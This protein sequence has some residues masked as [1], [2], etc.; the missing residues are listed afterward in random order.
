VL[1]LVLFEQT[2]NVLHELALYSHNILLLLVFIINLWYFGFKAF[3][4]MS[5]Q[6]VVIS[7]GNFLEVVRQNIAFLE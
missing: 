4:Q 2:L 6:L 5:L 1:L 3:G 7:I